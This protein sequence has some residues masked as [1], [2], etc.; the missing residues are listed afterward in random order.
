MN[1]HTTEMHVRALVRG[2]ANEGAQVEAGWR[3]TAAPEARA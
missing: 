2:L 1:P 3:A